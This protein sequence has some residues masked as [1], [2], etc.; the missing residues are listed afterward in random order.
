MKKQNIE[1][2]KE[3]GRETIGVFSIAKLRMIRKVRRN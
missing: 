1:C 2:D 3:Q